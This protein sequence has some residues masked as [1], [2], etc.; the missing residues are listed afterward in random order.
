[1][2]PPGLAINTTG[3]IVSVATG[4]IPASAFTFFLTANSFSCGVARKSI[5]HA[6]PFI[7]QIVPA[8]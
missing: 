1:M 7:S 5:L 6:N 3:Y 4:S 2:P 8:L